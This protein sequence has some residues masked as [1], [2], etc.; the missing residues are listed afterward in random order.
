MSQRKK[1]LSLVCAELESEAERS[2]RNYRS[3]HRRHHRYSAV[4]R[5]RMYLTLSRALRDAPT[6]AQID[7]ILDRV[8]NVLRPFNGTALRL[9]QEIRLERYTGII[10]AA[11]RIK[12]P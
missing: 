9:R 10:A 5:G 1:L 2:I 8:I 4:V 12:G 7:P 11:R 3:Y 6:D